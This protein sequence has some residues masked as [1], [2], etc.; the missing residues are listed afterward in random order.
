MF[1]NTV[2]TLFEGNGILLAS[3]NSMDEF[4][5]EVKRIIQ[6]YTHPPI[7]DPRSDSE[8]HY[9]Y[10]NV[11]ITSPKF[12]PQE[13]RLRNLSYNGDVLVEIIE[14]T[15]NKDGSKVV[16]VHPLVKI[17]E[18]P[19]MLRSSLCRLY[20]LTE[21]QTIAAGECIYNKGGYFIQNGKEKVIISQER[22]GYNQV[23]VHPP[24][25]ANEKKVYRLV[26]ETRTVI[27][28]GAKPAIVKLL[29]SMDNKKID[30]IMPGLA[31]PVN[32][33]AV[34]SYYGCNSEEKVRDYITGPR[35]R[36]EEKEHAK[37]HAKEHNKEIFHDM[38]EYI[39]YNS[40]DALEDPISF[41]S[42]GFSEAVEKKHIDDAIHH[43]L[44]DDIFPNIPPDPKR[45]VAYLSFM[46][47]QLLLVASGC[48][49][50][51]D[52]DNFV[53]KRVDMAGKLLEDLFRGF[54]NDF[55]N[56][57][58]SKLSSQPGSLSIFERETCITVGI[59]MCMS[60]GNWGVQ[61]NGY[62]KVG[63]CQTITNISYLSVLSHCR[64]T[65]SNRTTEGKATK[66]RQL[67]YSQW[68]IFDPAETPEGEM[69]GI[70]KN[71]TIGFYVTGYIDTTHVKRL[72]LEMK[73]V[74]SSF[75]RHDRIRILVDGELIGMTSQPEEV[76]RYLRLKRQEGIINGN[77]SIT[78]RDVDDVIVIWGEAS[79]TCRPLLVVGSKWPEK[80]EEMLQTWSDLLRSGIIRYVDSSEEEYSLVS[81]LPE[82]IRRGSH[83]AEIHPTM[84]LGVITGTIPFCNHCP[85]PRNSYSDN[86]AKQAISAYALNYLQ[87]YDV[88]LYILQQP[89]VPV[90]QT[91]ISRLID[92]N[93]LPCGQNAIVAVA[94]RGFNQEDSVM[95][96][97]SSVQ[98]ELFSIAIHKAYVGEERNQ[99]NQLITTVELP[100]PGARNRMYNYLK[101]N[102]NGII[103]KGAKVKKFDVLIGMTT[104]REGRTSEPH[105]SSLYYKL[106]EEGV[107]GDILVTRNGDGN[108]IVRVKVIFYR[109]LQPG[110]KLANR[111]AQKGT[112][113]ILVKG[114]DM[115][116]TSS[117]LVPDLFINTAA[118]P[119]RMTTHQ[120]LE[121]LIGKYGLLK[122]E[123]QDASPFQDVQSK[124][125]S[126]MEGLK[127]LGFH[128]RGEERMYDGTTG[129]MFEASI[130]LGPVYYQ[131]LKHLILD[132]LS[133]RS[134]GP[135]TN[136]LHQPANQGRKNGTELTAN[137][138]GTME[139][140]AFISHGG[141]FSLYDRLM[142]CSDK[143]TIQVCSACGNIPN[144][145]ACCGEIT[146]VPV[147]YVFKLIRQNVA[148]MMVN[149]RINPKV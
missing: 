100:P 136:L 149:M 87:R 1:A 106:D 77:V 147:P 98:M 18:I 19:I 52:R 69:A 4:Y 134:T 80:P 28:R 11:M 130:F 115:P 105:D 67:H 94:P 27:V 31:T 57:V 119:S 72:L 114:E 21:S 132:K 93:N 125:E 92:Y 85:G 23:V 2:K 17:A 110:D 56:N 124:L 60:T 41:I 40:E 3:L 46:A 103:R 58:F 6:G 54:F 33:L 32:L 89:Q 117:G 82:K 81:P 137:R 63:V 112:T 138:V 135:M 75:D 5:E 45:K 111:D 62:K 16:I 66:M 20:G 65:C 76:V 9:S 96:N 104:R 91:E 64:R 90:V 78:Y 48:R 84:I 37:E 88:S 109:P 38:I 59:R 53:I 34:L 133:A 102:P 142:V 51:D 127:E 13:C 74:E 148:G 30:I 47:Y 44:Y 83:Y 36:G 26:C 141:P 39:L 25:K 43:M 123:F 35:V 24:V 99:G 50:V 122:G 101:L 139:A 14:T 144:S 107:V 15:E 97:A 126:V 146:T 86:M 113:G 7:K 108:K 73:E 121:M 120:F 118:F 12:Y 129:E 145:K 49:S 95:I 131:R 143:Y 10:G 8:R 61:K 128:P 55:N 68:G 70:I 116:F 71:H 79:R 140:D 22:S 29:L 42:K